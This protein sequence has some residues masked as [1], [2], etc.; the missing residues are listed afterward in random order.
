MTC[1]SKKWHK[2]LLSLLGFENDKDLDLQWL[3]PVHTPHVVDYVKKSSILIYISMEKWF[4]ELTDEAS[5]IFHH[6]NMF[7][8]L[9]A[10]ID[11]NESLK[12]M[13]QTLFVWMRMAFTVDLVIGIGRIIDDRKDS[14]SLIRFL[15]ELKTRED[16]LSRR[17]YVEKYNN[18]SNIDS[19][20]KY[21]LEIANKHFDSLAGEEIDVYPVNKIEEDISRITQQSPCKDI[22]NFRNQYSAHLSKVKYSVPT[23]DELFI[24][25]RAIEEVFK[26]FNFIMNAADIDTMTPM[27]Q[28]DWQK[29]L[30][31]PWSVEGIGTDSKSEP[32]NVPK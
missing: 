26:K 17:K 27:P 4:K 16:Y 2:E 18:S 9:G 20:Q 31:I 10:I 23:Y 7:R 22:I 29:P 30:T 3:H 6:L 11:R 12:K 1:E 32:E 19:T 15:H 5:L 14:L 28:G 25:F 8:Q 13:D 21:L 24:A